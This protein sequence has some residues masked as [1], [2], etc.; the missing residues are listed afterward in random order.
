MKD[1]SN[2]ALHAD[3]L[4]AGR[5]DSRD[6]VGSITAPALVMRGANDC[7][8]PPEMPVELASMLPHA[9][10]SII[11]DAGH[12]VMLEARNAFNKR[13]SAFFENCR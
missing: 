13:V 10:L 2:P 12:V 7:V 4:A 11:E 9:E 8:T 5:F 3:L 1:N 6:W